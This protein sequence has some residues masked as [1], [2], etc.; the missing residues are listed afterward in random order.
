MLFTRAGIWAPGLSGDKKGVVCEKDSSPYS[1]SGGLEFLPGLYVAHDGGGGEGGCRGC[2]G[3][4]GF[5]IG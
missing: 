3:Y 5:T 4:R 2:R 1:V